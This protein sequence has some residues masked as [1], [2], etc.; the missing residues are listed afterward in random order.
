ML[1]C[2][3]TPAGHRVW[4]SGEF[5]SEFNSC[6]DSAPVVSSVGSRVNAEALDL[7]RDADV[8]YDSGYEA[9]NEED[10]WSETG[11]EGDEDESPTSA[12]VFCQAD[13]NSH[14]LEGHLART[15]CIALTQEGEDF[16][17]D[18]WE[19]PTEFSR[20]EGMTTR[21]PTPPG[22]SPGDCCGDGTAE[23]IFGRFAALHAKEQPVCQSLRQLPKDTQAA[24]SEHSIQ[25]STMW[26]RSSSRPPAKLPL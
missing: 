5:D 4:Q 26:Q 7:D 6:A 9:E 17:G 23:K 8:D 16:S 19:I 15:N 3:E 1:Y 2:N 24:P 20:A 21:T 11:S 10:A 12:D 13:E 22:E 18:E 14:S 25:P